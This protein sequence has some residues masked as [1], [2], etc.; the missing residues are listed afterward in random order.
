MDDPE[1]G[2]EYDSESELIAE[3]DA[4]ITVEAAVAYDALVADSSSSCCAPGPVQA[5][6]GDTTSLH[7][8]RT[9][10]VHARLSPCG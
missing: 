2:R 7:F 8:G 10:E 9:S 1:F 4:E 5:P 3:V 6:T